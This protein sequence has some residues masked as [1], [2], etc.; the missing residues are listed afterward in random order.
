MTEIY[1][2]VYTEKR[3]EQQNKQ[4]VILIEKGFNMEGFEIYP[5]GILRNSNMSEDETV[6]VPDG[7]LHISNAAFRFHQMR[8][9]IL[10][11]GLL[12][13]TDSA[14]EECEQLEKVHFS[15]SLKEIGIS[16]FYGCAGL[17]EIRLPS[18]LSKIE[19]GAF[20]G[21]GLEDI[22]VP[23]SIKKYKGAFNGCVHLKKAI[24]EDGVKQVDESAFSGCSS[25]TEV[26]L[27]N[28]ITEIKSYAFFG[29][30]SLE[31]IV[32]PETVKI[33]GQSAF[34]GCKNLKSINLP[35]NLKKLGKNAFKGCD[36]L[37][38]SAIPKHFLKE[39]AVKPK[40]EVIEVADNADM[41]VFGNDSGTV[42]GLKNRKAHYTTVC[43]PNGVRVVQSSA[44][45]GLN[46]KNVVLPDGLEKIEGNA[47]KNCVNFKKI[48]IPKSVK[49]VEK[50]AFAGCKLLHV[51]C[52]SNPQ[53]SWI[54]LPDEQ[55]M[56]CD[57]MTDAFN[58]HRSGGSFDDHYIV[59]RTE[60]I[61]NSYNPEKRPV[62]TN[63]PREEFLTL[64][65]TE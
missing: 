4:Q 38:P 27:P 58:F 24:I 41:F 19:S 14:C 40:P 22:V 56:F 43:V 45:S 36:S 61:K 3:Y 64:L 23:A 49:T 47:F 16:T 51:Y 7:V 6:I 2:F 39:T 30:T 8:E 48:F 60:I 54:D 28:G 50:D 44:F 5:N 9:L 55:K 52:E 12:S 25:L 34:E 62:H 29:C 21:S 63:V 10:P 11:E 17:K 65:K 13:I 20:F 18:K 31:S 35:E 42:T 32:I 1:D 33:I 37:P 57:D 53:E 15:Q 46:V 26:V 59:E